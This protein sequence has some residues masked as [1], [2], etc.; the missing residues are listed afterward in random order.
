ME[1]HENKY[2][3]IDTNCYEV[4]GLP[5]LW[6]IKV[7]VFNLK[8]GQ[9]VI[10][11]Q[12]EDEWEAIVRFDETLPFEKQWYVELISDLPPS[13]FDRQKGRDD[14]YMDGRCSGIL[15]EK[16][17]IA[18]KMLS[19]GLD[20]NFVEKYTGLYREKIINLREWVMNKND[21]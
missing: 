13:S 7:E 17:N 2:I 10:A 1:S 15:S 6:R 16:I 5:T 8:E 14:G 21:K 4:F 12:D 18:I 9:K 3:E 20:I 11:Y 19:D